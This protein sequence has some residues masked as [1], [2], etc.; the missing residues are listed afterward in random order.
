M[1]RTLPASLLP[2]L[3]T[4]SLLAGAS[5]AGD[6]K[7]KESKPR[8]DFS[9]TWQLD[10]AKSDYGIFGDRP[11]AKADATL[12]VEHKEPE[13][14]ITRTLRLN[15]REETGVF[16]YYTDERGEANPAAIGPGDVR[17]K[18]KW[19]GD[20]VVARASIR[21]KGSGGVGAGLDVTQ[22]WYVSSDGKTLTNTTAI[23]DGM[24]GQLIKLV[25]RRGV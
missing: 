1:K 13:L 15:G 19:E 11:I 17:S 10:R 3:V 25:Y 18:T 14:K 8:P 24:G 22:K 12:V 20:K 23:G 5:A 6:D 16:T 4:L 2:A 9:G 7:K 21:G